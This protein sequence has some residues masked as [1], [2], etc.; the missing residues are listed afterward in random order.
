MGRGRGGDDQLLAVEGVVIDGLIVAVGG[1]VHHGQHRAGVGGL[2][3]V[4][5]LLA[6]AG[7]DQC[8]GQVGVHVVG[9]HRDDVGAGQ[10]LVL[11]LGQQGLVDLKAGVQRV[12]HEVGVDHGVV[13]VGQL[14][15]QQ[16]GLH[17]DDLDAVGDD[18]R[19]GRG[20]A[21]ALL[22]LDDAVV[23]Q[24]LQRAGLVGGVVRHADGDV[25]QRGHGSDDQQ[26]GHKRRDELANIHGFT[27]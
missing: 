9:V 18:V 6:A 7:G 11:G 26:C 24:Q 5:H 3:V 19:L 2:D 13:Q 23:G 12:Q 25:G 20:L 22:E 4:L 15:H 8:L 10:V 1:L 16:V 27:S 17:L 21:R 14:V